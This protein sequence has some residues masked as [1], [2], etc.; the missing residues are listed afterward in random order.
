M[1]DVRM[2]WFAVVR[3]HAVVRMYAV[4]RMF[5]VVRMHAVVRMFV[6]LPGMCYIGMYHQT[7][8]HYG[9]ENGTHHPGQI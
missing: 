3:M 4:V 1:I 6:Q 8:G 7:Q 9:R 2:L 5:A